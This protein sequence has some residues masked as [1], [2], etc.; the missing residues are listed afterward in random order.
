MP[1]TFSHPAAILPFT[2]LKPQWFSLTALIIGSLSPDFEYFIRMKMYGHYSHTIQGVVFFDLPLVVLL[3]FVYHNIVRNELVSNLP[4]FLSSRLNN[5]KGFDWN[6]FFKKNFLVVIISAFIGII[7]HVVWDGFTH[8]NGFF[9]ENI[10]G[11]KSVFY[12]GGHRFQLF[13]LLQHFSSLAGMAL[14]V[15]WVIRLQK[16]NE[17]SKSDLPRY[18]IKVFVVFAI[19]LVIRY[20]LGNA[21]A[22]IKQFVVPC[23][24]SM[25]VALVVVPLY[26]RT[27]IFFSS[28]QKAL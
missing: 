20:F 12:I 6:A 4:A 8:A 21:I 7:S 1:F 16:N 23:I 13:N 5:F 11:L 9:V 3:S 22:N 2:K 14:I 24:S 15:F 27:I 17:E 10:R 26:N 19:V 18:W 25:L 28:K